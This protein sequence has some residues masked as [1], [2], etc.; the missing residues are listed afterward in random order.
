MQAIQQNVNQEAIIYNLSLA[1]KE[2]R[3]DIKVHAKYAL[4]YSVVALIFKGLHDLAL[5]QP[6]ELVVNYTLNT[7]NVGIAACIFA[8]A[9]HWMYG[10]NKSQEIKKEITYAVVSLEELN[11]KEQDILRLR[12]ENL[13]LRQELAEAC[14]N[15]NI[16]LPEY[17]DIRINH[18]QEQLN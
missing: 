18:L 15:L 17:S 13:Q 2:A 3:N 6:S 10:M 9:I 1:A 12:E 14:K 8:G 7:L 11:E 4:P 16:P 5:T